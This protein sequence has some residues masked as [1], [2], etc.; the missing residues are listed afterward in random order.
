[1][2]INSYFLENNWEKLKQAYK[3]SMFLFYK[4]SM[5]SYLSIFYCIFFFNFFKTQQISLYPSDIH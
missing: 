4:F 5:S 3:L 2:E 1:M